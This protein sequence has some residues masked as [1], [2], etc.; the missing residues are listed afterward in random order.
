MEKI[1]VESGRKR[2]LVTGASEGIGRAFAIALA[3]RGWEVTA[4]ARSSARLDELLGELKGSGHSKIVADLSKAEGISRVAGEISG[5]AGYRLLVNNAGFGDIGRFEE[6]SIERIREMIA[7]NVLAVVELS[8]AFL[9]VAR[10]GDG[11]IQVSST[12]A[13]TPMPAQPVYSAT[14]AF[15]T[16]FS[17]S[18]WFQSRAKGVHVMDL[19]PGA[20]R[21]Q[22]H[23]RAGGKKGEI[24][25][26]ILQTSEEV[27]EFALRCW[28]RKFGP[29]AVSGWKNRAMLALT[30]LLTRKQLSKLMGSVRS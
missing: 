22:F 5:A 9:R 29:T 10:R 21:S 18:L 7:L 20:T 15:V 13:F 23:A 6:Q 25:D 11:I 28:E 4:V 1:P 3:G 12:L 24:P 26:A 8:H 30:R 2:A 16:S 27:V 19:C 14:K 17:E